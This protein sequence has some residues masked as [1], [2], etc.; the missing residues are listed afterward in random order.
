MVG[1]EW[2]WYSSAQLTGGGASVF[3]RVGQEW[4]LEQDLA[5]GD[6]GNGDQFGSSVAIAGDLIVIGAPLD[7]DEVNES[8]GSAY[9]FSRADGEW[10]ELQKLVP[11]AASPWQQFG[12]SVAVAGA[13]LLVGSP[14]YSTG[15]V[16]RAGC[17]YL[18]RPSGGS[19]IQTSLLVA[20]GAARDDE[21]GEVAMSGHTAVLGARLAD[22]D[23]RTD[24]GTAYVFLLP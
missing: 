1:A 24:A 18:F 19:W 2:R 4:V 6:P 5:A 10:S 14:G 15:S 21:L 3:A 9:L 17:A 12:W 22:V 20:A 8:S 13:N 11:F 23:G 16:W 7:D